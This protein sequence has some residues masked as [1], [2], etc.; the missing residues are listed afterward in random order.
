MHLSDL[1]LAGKYRTLY[2]LYGKLNIPLSVY[3]PDA[4]SAVSEIIYNWREEIDGI[5]IS[6]DIATTGSYHDLEHAR[7]LLFRSTHGWLSNKKTSTPAPNGLIKPIILVPGNH[8]RYA[9]LAGFPGKKFYTLFSSY[10]AAGIGGVQTFFLPDAG[11]PILSIVSVDFSLENI[12]DSSCR[13]GHYGQGKVYVDRLQNLVKET[14]RITRSYH[15]CGVVW[16]VH[17]APEFERHHQL[18]PRMVLI[19]SN[20]LIEAAEEVGVKYI[21]CGHTHRYADYLAKTDGRVQIHCA[22]TSL[23]VEDDQD[24][25][26]HLR[27]IELDGSN[28]VK[29]MSLPYRYDPDRLIFSD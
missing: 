11:L 10:W 16:M 5:L 26:I 15:D 13:F 28:V 4:L 29:V 24:T 3:N 19:D 21:F 17:F 27:I 6:G 2:E 25:T 12:R 20:D 1:H 22:G 18:D 9:S 7:E 8:D 23:C 14:E